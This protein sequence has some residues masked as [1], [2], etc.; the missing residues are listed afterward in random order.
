MA[1]AIR[2]L[3]GEDEAAIAAEAANGAPVL[4]LVTSLL[5]RAA[6]EE[7]AALPDASSLTVGEAQ[8]LA[9][10][11]R[12]A[13]LDG[14]LRTSLTCS[15]CGEVLSLDLDARDLVAPAA[16]VEA[17]I[18]AAG[19]VLTCRAPRVAD[20][21]AAGAVGDPLAA[22]RALLT[23]CVSATDAGGRDVPIADLPDA[24][25]DAAA[26]HLLA[27]DPNAE[28]V[29]ACAC[30][31]CGAALSAVLDPAGFLLAEL[32]GQEDALFAEV[33]AIAARTGWEEASILAMPRRRRKAYAAALGAA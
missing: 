7:G 32:A 8:A 31:S 33:L 3:T 26:S 6:R 28:T 17:V 13:S 10:R 27:L 12:S 4:G 29:L 21:L 14:P 25:A 16:S 30:P 9:L 22:A 11:L 24:V 1:I 18:V 19:I 15:A 5:E 20:V 2:A 23:R